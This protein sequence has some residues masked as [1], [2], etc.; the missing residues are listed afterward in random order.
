MGITKNDNESWSPLRP[1]KSLG[2]LGSAQK[3]A[4]CGMPTEQLPP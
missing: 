4:K 1:E 2:I 3:R